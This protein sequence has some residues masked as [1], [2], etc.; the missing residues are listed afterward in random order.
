MK[1]LRIFLVLSILTLSA[2]AQGNSNGSNGCLDPD[3]LVLVTV[4][5]YAI[6]D[7]SYQCAKYF[8]DEDGDGVAE[9]RLNFGPVW[10]EPDSSLAIRP[11]VSDS[12]WVFGAL[13]NQTEFCSIDSLPMVVVFEINDEFWRDPFEP[14]W[15]NMGHHHQ[16]SHGY[17]FGWRNDSL[18]SVQVSGLVI[19]DTAFVN[20][21]Y[22]LDEDEDDLPD[23]VLNF[24]PPWY[25]PVDSTL[26]RPVEGDFISIT[27][28]LINRTNLPMII[29]YE[30]NG[31]IW[32]DSTLMAN[33]LG[34]KWIYRYMNQNRHV[35]APF[36]TSDGFVVSPGWHGGQGPGMH[37]AALLPPSSP[38]ALP[39]RRHCPSCRRWNDWA[40]FPPPPISAMS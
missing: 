10:Y 13:V 31:E 8:L 21:H 7:T 17:A 35:H 24:G 30:I 23:Y 12:I 34:G 25:E 40:L 15:T 29:V 39:G 38:A 22:F 9:Y 14:L 6:V 18:I 28:G 37:G 26:S 1:F 20:T 11:A 16:H 2:F 19:L 33:N 4:T 36:D 3:S 32:R 5:G 27:G